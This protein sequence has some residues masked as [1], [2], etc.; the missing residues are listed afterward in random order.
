MDKRPTVA[1]NADTQTC[2][3]DSIVF[4]SCHQTAIAMCYAVHGNRSG[5]IVTVVQWSR[6]MH[7][8][9]GHIMPPRIDAPRSAD[10]LYTVVKYRYTVLTVGKHEDHC[11][12]STIT[13]CLHKRHSRGLNHHRLCASRMCKP[14]G[15]RSP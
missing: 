12:R 11:L 4:F 6:H 8:S 1:Y 7:N 15:Y 13:K 10:L 5:H 14:L 2:F 9:L 3:S